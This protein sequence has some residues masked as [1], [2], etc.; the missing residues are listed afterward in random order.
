[1]GRIRNPLV[2]LIVGALLLACAVPA[3]PWGKSSPRWP[4]S[5]RVETPSPTGAPSRAATEASGTPSSF[6]GLLQVHFIDVGQGD[7]T[8][9]ITPDGKAALIDGGEPDSGAARYLRTVGVEKLDLVVNTHPH[10]D[11]VGGLIEVLQTIPV[12]SVAAGGQESTSSLYEKFLDAVDASKARYVEVQRGQTLSLGK[13]ELKVLSP[14]DSSSTGDLNSTSVVLRLV[15]GKT[16]FLFMG[17]ADKQAEKAILDAGLDV[18]ANVLKVG[19]HASR[20]G[21]SPEFLA[22]VRPEMAI[23]F[24]GK[25]NPFGHPHAETL[26]ALRAVKAVIYGTD[27]AGTIVVTA[28]GNGYTVRGG[29]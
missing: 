2:S 3:S 5:P 23:Y 4:P 10:S 12:A 28:D 7:S 6:A 14:P 25:G 16:A 20:D 22:R 15:Y 26:A 21:S 24:A 29:Q 1:M 18:Q 27:T 11:H 19:H 13:L 8:L 9:I 17:D